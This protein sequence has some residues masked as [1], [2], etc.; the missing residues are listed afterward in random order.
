MKKVVVDASV[1]AKWFFPE[2]HSRAAGR[3]LSR[4]FQLIAPDLLAAEFGNLTWKRVRRR[5]ITP[6]DAASLI[7]DFLRMPLALV[8]SGPLLSVALD[9]AVN[10]GR[11]VYDCLYL[12]LALNQDAVFVTADKRLANALSALPLAGHIQLIG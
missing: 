8:S 10:T 6:A 12:A 1:V 11:T 9:L 3:L 2:E 5:E 7:K 4:R